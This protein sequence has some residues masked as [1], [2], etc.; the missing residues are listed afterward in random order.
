MP[1]RNLSLRTNELEVWLSACGFNS[2]TL[3]PLAGDASFRRYFRVTA[4]QKSFIVMDVPSGEDCRPFIAIANALRQLQLQTPVILE[5]NLTQGFLLLTD[6][7]DTT[8]L[9]GLNK[10]NANSLYQLALNKLTIL[11]TCQQV[12]GYAIPPFTREWMWQEWRWHQEW[13][14]DKLL[15]LP[16]ISDNLEKEYALIVESAATQPQVFMH[17]DFHSANL[18]ILPHDVGILDFQDAFIGPITYDLASLLRD[19]YIDWPQENIKQWLSDYWQMMQK[20]YDVV[21]Y[22]EFIKWFDW[23]CV[24]RHLKA[25]LTFAR[26]KM[27]DQQSH[28][29]Q[30]IPRTLSY[31]VEVTKQYPEL[32]AIHDYYLGI[33]NLCEQ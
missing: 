19:C 10:D 12:E 33:F 21:E 24:Q 20:N 15:G 26:K 22:Q 11:Q 18:M 17:R 13:F 8:Y 4:Q 16:P 9:R 1:A 3:Q 25:L 28:Y 29:L 23:M 7:G 14:L 27:R 6:F 32:S 5:A 31:I 2:F 30:Y